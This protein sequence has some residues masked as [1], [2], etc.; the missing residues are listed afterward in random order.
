MNVTI[1]HIGT[2][3]ISPL[4]ALCVVLAILYLMTRRRR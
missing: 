3:S 2:L 1:A 4:A